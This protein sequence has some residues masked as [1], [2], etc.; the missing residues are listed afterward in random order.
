[1][2][3]RK[4]TFI[5]VHGEVTRVHNKQADHSIETKTLERYSEMWVY[6]WKELGKNVLE[7][8]PALTEIL[9]RTEEYTNSK[10]LVLQKYD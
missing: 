2:C 4:G 9:A 3:E 6:A 1:M 7:T 10:V 8:L 5:V